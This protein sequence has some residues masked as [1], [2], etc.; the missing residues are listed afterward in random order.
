MYI[1][2]E[3]HTSDDKEFTYEDLKR[4]YFR[5]LSDNMISEIIPHAVF[6]PEDDDRSFASEMKMENEFSVRVEVMYYDLSSNQI[7]LGLG[8]QNLNYYS[9]EFILDGQLGKRYNNVKFMAKLI[10]HYYPDILSFYRFHHTFD[11]FKKDKLFSK[12]DKLAFNQKDERF[13]EIEGCLPFLIQRKDWSTGFAMQI[14]DR[15]FQN[16]VI[17]FDK[18]KFDKSGYHLFGGSVSFNGSTLNSRQ[19]PFKVQRSPW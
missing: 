15:Y 13:P 1:K 14:E 6:N 9:K 4:G 18:D 17:D 10:C 16:S 5:L 11:Y 8:Y 19:F 7:Y 3:F 12:N 2:K